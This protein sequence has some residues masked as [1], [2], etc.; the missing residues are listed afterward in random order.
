[1]T[2]VI[3]HQQIGWIMNHP[4]EIVQL[5]QLLWACVNDATQRDEAVSEVLSL[6]ADVAHGVAI[7]SLIAILL[8]CLVAL[9][10]RPRIPRGALWV[11]AFGLFGGTPTFYTHTRPA[12]V[13]GFFLRS[14]H[15]VATAS[16]RGRC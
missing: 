11:P 15:R 6:L 3:D 8:V 10:Y 4:S 5:K 7:P 2:A 9:L 14:R 13:C 16:R 12:S 1:M